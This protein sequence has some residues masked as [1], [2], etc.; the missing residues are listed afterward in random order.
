MSLVAG[1]CG[2]TAAAGNA[3]VNSLTDISYIVPL[4][5]GT[6]ASVQVGQAVGQARGRDAVNRVA[7]AS[8]LRGVVGCVFNAAVFLLAG[9]WICSC[10]SPD[11]AVIA[12]AVA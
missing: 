9:R 3:I 10:F 11:E 4:G 5:I 2:T 6:L 1:M 12:V 8:L 7:R